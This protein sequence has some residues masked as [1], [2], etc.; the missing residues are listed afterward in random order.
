MIRKY[1]VSCFLLT[2]PILA[3]NLLLADRLP[4]V[5]QPDI[6][7]YNIP[8]LLAAGEDVFR[9]LIFLLTICMPLS[10][11]SAKQR[12]GLMVYL[13]GIVTYFASWIALI[14]F[15]SSA[16]SLSLPG[17]L[18]PAYTPA[19]WLTGIALIGDRF[20]FR[21]PYRRQYFI[22]PS[23]IFLAFHIAHTIIIFDRTY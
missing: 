15:P 3:W 7:W 2:I 14:C 21:I 12:S 1:L 8:F 16:W 19:I 4:R 6:F 17:F 10:I 18:A 22:I 5:F 23:M 9:M 11:T 13:A 20:Y